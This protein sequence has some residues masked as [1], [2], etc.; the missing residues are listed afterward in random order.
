MLTPEQFTNWLLIRRGSATLSRIGQ[1]LGVSR[2][3]VH[4][5]L[6]GSS[7]PSSTVLLLAERIMREPCDLSCGLPGDGR[8]LAS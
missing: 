2:Q 5:W 4:Q 7:I 1:E 8:R 3:A 6:N